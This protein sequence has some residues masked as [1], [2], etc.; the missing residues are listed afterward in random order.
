MVRL[1]SDSQCFRLVW[2]SSTNPQKDA[3]L[4]ILPAKV[5]REVVLISHS[6]SDFLLDLMCVV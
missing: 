5:W 2:H 4:I 6:D 3:L 1:V